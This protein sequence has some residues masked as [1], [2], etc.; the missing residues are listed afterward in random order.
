MKKFFINPKETDFEVFWHLMAL[1]GKKG[2]NFI[3]TI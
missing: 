3:L 2:Q 1:D